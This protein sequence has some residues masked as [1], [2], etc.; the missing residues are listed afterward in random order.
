MPSPTSNS[1][2]G[3]INDAMRDAG[4]LGEG[5]EPNSEALAVNFRRLNDIINLWQ[6][7]G[8]KLF[9]LQEVTV[10]LVASQSIYTLGPTG[11]VVMAKPSRV[12]EG[13]ILQT[14]S[15]TRRPLTCLSWDEWVSLGQVVGNNGAIN[16]Y[17]V[18]KQATMLKVNVWP[19]PNTA[20]VSNTLRLLTQVQATNQI[21]LEDS[22]MF[23]QEWRIALRWGL[24]DDIAT[25]QPQAI[26]DRCQQRSN[27]YREALEDWDVEDTATTFV[28]DS[29][30]GY[31]GRGRF[32]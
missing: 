4:L 23:P 8:L 13:W 27:Q 6:T 19:P 22:M 9:Y 31:G 21:N 30:T 18:D 5:E 10:P 16:S 11:N 14:A 32:R 20:E 17:F 7:Q 24:A 12:L 1:I 3:I 25:G 29:N 28:V 26:M 15:N 2:Y